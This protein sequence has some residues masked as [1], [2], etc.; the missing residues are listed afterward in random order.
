M[1]DIKKEERMESKMQVDKYTKFILTVIAL[2]LVFLCLKGLTF[3]PLLY[4]SPQDT[5]DV[6]IKA[7]ERAPGQNWDPVMIGVTD[8]FPVEVEN[9]AA[10]P[11]EVKNA[12]LA[13]DVK[14]VDV[15]SSLKPVEVKK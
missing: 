4:G 5:I 10:I 8:K 7:I 13:V 14:N 1:P 11:V 12:L 9:E 3:S 15:K 2:C 6:R